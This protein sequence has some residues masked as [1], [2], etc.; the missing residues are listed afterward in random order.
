M[1]SMLGVIDPIAFQFGPIKVAWYGI[2]IAIGMFV[3]VWLSM[4]E[5]NKRGIG[6]DFIVDLAFWIIPIG[7]L[8]ARLYY[9]LFELPSY[10]SNP[11]R[12]FY[13]WE[14]GLAI[15]GGLIAGILTLYWYSNKKDVPVWL[16]L[17]V[18]APHVMIAQAIGRWGNFINQEAFGGEV[19]RS[20]LEKLQLPEFIINQMYIKE[21]YHHPT[22]LYE[23]VWNVIGFIILMVL[24]AK[25]N[26]FKRGEVFLAYIGWYGLG[27]FFIE[28]MRTDS[29]YIGA[30]RV[31]QLLSAVLL[32]GS[33]GLV[34]YRRMYVYPKPPYYTEGMDPDK[35][36]QEKRIKYEAKQKK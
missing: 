14:G 33:I 6:E 1:G 35:E 21:V 24:R 8:G 7:V 29:L 27:R 19:S 17:D 10:L 16:L 32:V 30:F 26:L 36:F 28:G 22:F 3:A 4:K 18:L 12:I 31:S 9:V 5:A 25:S 2:I 34:I 20:F 13:I 23:S 15:Y 11:I